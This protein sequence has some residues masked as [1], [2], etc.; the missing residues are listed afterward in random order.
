[1]LCCIEDLDQFCF[2]ATDLGLKKLTSVLQLFA[3]AWDL[4]R[5]PGS[6][7]LPMVLGGGFWREKRQPTV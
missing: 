6:C 4:V 5:G 1:M 2:C 7:P 3:T